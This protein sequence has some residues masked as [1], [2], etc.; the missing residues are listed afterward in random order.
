VFFINAERWDVL[1]PGAAQAS[2]AWTF[3]GIWATW[4][5]KQEALS[6][7]KETS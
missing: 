7:K 2:I 4:A 5:G 1:L 3:V 6:Y